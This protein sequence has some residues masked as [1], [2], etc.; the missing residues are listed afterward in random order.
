[1]LAIAKLNPVATFPVVLSDDQIDAAIYKIDAV[2]NG[3]VDDGVDVP[4][5]MS[6][7]L[8]EMREIIRKLLAA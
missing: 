2:I 1:M 6:G 4:E 3:G 8:F 5:F 7:P